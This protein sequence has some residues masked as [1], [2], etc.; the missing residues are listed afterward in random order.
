MEEKND[1]D[2]E[3]MYNKF[4]EIA[5]EDLEEFDDRAVVIKP[6]EFVSIIAMHVM[7]GSTL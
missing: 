4:I 6:T 7:K 2:I 5:K 1:L 3:A